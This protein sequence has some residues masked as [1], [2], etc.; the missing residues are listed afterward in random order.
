MTAPPLDGTWRDTAAC[1]RFNPEDFDPRNPAVAHQAQQVCATCPV[2]RECLLDALTEEARTKYGPW[3][4][5]GG[6]TPKT[7]KNLT[8]A[9]RTDLIR[10]LTNELKENP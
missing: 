1:A 9:Q 5:R 7:R 6:L 10:E 4:I 3:L 2:R 8:R